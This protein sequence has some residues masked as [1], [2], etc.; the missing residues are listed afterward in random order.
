MPYLDKSKIELPKQ[1]SNYNVWADYIEL[2]VMLH[3]DRK[4][5]V[6]SIK[7]RLLDGNDGAK[8]ALRQINPMARSIITPNIDRIADDQFEDDT[9]PED[10]QR[11]KTAI[12]GVVDYMKCRNTIVSDYYPF[13]IDSRHAISLKEEL[14]NK[15]KIYIILL[16]SSL[17]RVITREGGF[18]YRITHRFENLCEHPFGLLIPQIAAKEFFGAG[19]PTNENGEQTSCLLYHKVEELSKNLRLNLNTEFRRESAGINNVGD[20]G[21][22]WVAWVSFADNQIGRAHV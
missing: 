14:T 22:D 3:P 13:T 11:I 5:S 15:N 10:E 8:K 2:F 16:I 12:L 17:I 18:A 19:G 21:L 20:G 7:D 9:D 4:L 1:E 6:E